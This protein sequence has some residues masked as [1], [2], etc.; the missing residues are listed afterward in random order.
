[1]LVFSLLVGKVTKD[2]G[3]VST[4]DL[5]W[6]IGLFIAFCPVIYA[7]KYLPVTGGPGGLPFFN[8]IS[9]GLA[10]FFTGLYFTYG[11]ITIS[12]DYDFLLPLVTA[13]PAILAGM[14]GAFLGWFNIAIMFPRPVA[15]VQHQGSPA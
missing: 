5:A 3:M 2:A 15:K 9:M 13:I 6:F 4:G 12:K 7:M 1:V 11:G 8:G 14:L 10:M